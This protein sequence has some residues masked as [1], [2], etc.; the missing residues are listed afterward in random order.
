M[1]KRTLDLKERHILLIYDNCK[2]HVSGFSNWWMKNI[3]CYKLTVTPYS[4]EFNPVERFFNSIKCKASDGV[5]RE[6]ILVLAEFLVWHMN[7][8]N[9]NLFKSYFQ[10]SLEEMAEHI[11]TFSKVEDDEYTHP[12]DRIPWK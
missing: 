6:D 4:P 11:M 9:S 8:L 3:R 7:Q 10:L 1:L 12:K 2:S 5:K